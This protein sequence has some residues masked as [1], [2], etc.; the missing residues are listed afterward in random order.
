MAEGQ[1]KYHDRV[2]VGFNMNKQDRKM[3]DE[4][5]KHHSMN[6]TQLVIALIKREYLKIQKA[7]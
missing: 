6:A 5:C 1:S 4:V 2:H 7:K 3:L